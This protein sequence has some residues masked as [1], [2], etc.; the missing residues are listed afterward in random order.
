VRGRSRQRR[1]SRR[2]AT[3]AARAL[4]PSVRA[5]TEM[6][7][8]AARDDGDRT[9]THRGLRW[10][11]AARHRHR[12]CGSRAL[13]DLRRVTDLE[14]K[15]WPDAVVVALRRTPTPPSRRG[16]TTAGA[17]ELAGALRGASVTTTCRS[18]TR[19]CRA[20]GIDAGEAKAPATGS[21]SAPTA[22]A[23]DRGDRAEDR[24][25]NPGSAGPR[26][27]S[28]SRAWLRAG[29]PPALPATRRAAPRQGPGRRPD[30]PGRRGARH[31]AVEL[32]RARAGAETKCA[33]ST[34]D[35]VSDPNHRL[36]RWVWV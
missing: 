19:A 15:P 2:L 6:L 16:R 33:A 21:C 31:R 24:A 18:G 23:R 22:A 28:C 5:P 32:P 12:S 13:R 4:R 25:R 3:D 7:L 29:T 8:Q 10:V 11:P 17:F 20:P 35:L 14:G 34:G 30:R 1:A 26:S 9:P 27:R 36:R